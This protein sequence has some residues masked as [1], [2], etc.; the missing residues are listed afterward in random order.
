[1]S[2]GKTIKDAVHRKYP[3]VL[4]EDNLET[5]MQTMK[6]NNASA[7]V[8]MSGEHLIGLVTISDVIFCLANEND[9]AETKISSFMTEC[10]LIG[11]E[12][13]ANPCAQ[14]DENYDALSAIKVMHEAGVNHLLVSG[15][16]G[17]AVGIVSSLEL[18]KLLAS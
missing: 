13:T 11:K 10:E 18:V 4:Y 5:A 3:S 15:K 6:A 9:L 8:V 16:D 12:G 17:E 7:L 1:M 14:L 2:E